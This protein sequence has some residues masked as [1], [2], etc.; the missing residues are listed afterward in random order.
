[1]CQGHKLQ[2]FPW[3]GKWSAIKSAAEG[4]GLLL[5]YEEQLPPGQILVENIMAIVGGGSWGGYPG[6][7][8]VWGYG[9]VIAL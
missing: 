6:W 8:K 1:M 3:E 9:R 4:I 2:Y 5:V 7:Y